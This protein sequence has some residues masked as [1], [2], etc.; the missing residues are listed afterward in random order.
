MHPYTGH[1][2]LVDSPLHERMM[3]V[4]LQLSRHGVVIPLFAE[5]LLAVPTSGIFGPVRTGQLFV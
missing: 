3:L 2:C 5:E 1:V 4:L